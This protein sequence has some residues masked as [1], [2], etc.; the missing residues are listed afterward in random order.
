LGGKLIFLKKGHS[1][2]LLEKSR[3]TVAK[4]SQSML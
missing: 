3:D 2:I 4:S 1:E